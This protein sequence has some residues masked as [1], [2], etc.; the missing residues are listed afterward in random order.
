M[1]SVEPPFRCVA[2]DLVSTVDESARTRDGRLPQ[3]RKVER[4][5]AAL[6]RSRKLATHAIRALR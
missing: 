4:T 6:D 2:R 5:E 1:A 3:M